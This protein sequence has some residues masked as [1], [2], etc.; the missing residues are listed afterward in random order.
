MADMNPTTSIIILNVN[1]INRPI[2]RQETATVTTKTRPNC[3][4]ST[5]TLF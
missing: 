2:K 5:R 4:L 3:T 1:D